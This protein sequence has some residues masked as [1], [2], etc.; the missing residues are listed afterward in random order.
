MVKHLSYIQVVLCLSASL[1]F[2]AIQFTGG[3]QYPSNKS[4]VLLQ[5]RDGPTRNSPPLARL[6][7]YALPN[8]IFST[9]NALLLLA[10]GTAYYTHLDIT[11]TT[12]DQGIPCT[13]AQYH[14]GVWMAWK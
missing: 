14:E 6:C 9:G 10:T 4:Y 7:G 8:P 3:C 12:T 13:C 11:Y 5:V 1:F 2:I